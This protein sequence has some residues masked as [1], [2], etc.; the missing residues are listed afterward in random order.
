MKNRAHESQSIR[1]A[2]PEPFDA[3]FE[4]IDVWSSRLAV[5]TMVICVFYFVPV[6][7][8]IILK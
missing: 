6:F 8:K 3:F 2:G 5:A 4:F 7:I 1:G